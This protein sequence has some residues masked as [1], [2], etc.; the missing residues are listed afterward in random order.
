MSFRFPSQVASTVGGKI[1]EEG[2]DSI[3]WKDLVGGLGAMIGC[4]AIAGSIAFGADQH[5]NPTK[6]PA[7]N[8]TE[9]NARMINLRFI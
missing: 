8:S 4:G 2:F 1:T 7:D 9:E 5:S 6:S 3:F